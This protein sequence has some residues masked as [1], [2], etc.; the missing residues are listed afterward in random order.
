MHR[1][2]LGIINE[3][4]TKTRYEPIIYI[5]GIHQPLYHCVYQD[6]IKAIKFF[7]SHRPFKDALMYTLIKVYNIS[8]QRVYNELYTAD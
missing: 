7:I 5:Q 1:L 6:I 3:K 8:N 2:L 4:W